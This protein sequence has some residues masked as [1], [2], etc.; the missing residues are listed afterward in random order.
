MG[1]SGPLDFA[2]AVT[3]DVGSLPA[4]G[5]IIYKDFLFTQLHQPM[6]TN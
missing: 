1:S 4:G 2:L 6:R 3:G 5:M